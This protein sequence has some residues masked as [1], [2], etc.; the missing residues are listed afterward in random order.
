MSSSK[1]SAS[2]SPSFKVPVKN[3]SG[4]LERKVFKKMLPFLFLSQSTAFFSYKEYFT[5]H[6]KRKIL[7]FLTTGIDMRVV[8]TADVPSHFNIR[9]KNSVT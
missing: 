6:L 7:P 3:L 2:V 4:E 1:T 5:M 9:L 8:G